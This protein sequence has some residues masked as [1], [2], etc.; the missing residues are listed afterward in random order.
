MALTA[1]V[2]V[3]HG[4]NDV[5]TSMLPAL[6]PSVQLRFGLGE[7]TLAALV[8]TFAFSSSLP[9]PLLGALAERISPRAAAALG[10]ALSATVLSLVGVVPSAALL[11][12][13][14]LIGGLGS[15]ALHPA[16]SVI[17]REAEADKADRAASLFTAGGMIGY[18]LGP[19]AILAIVAN[20]GLTATAWLMVPG[21]AL[22][23]ATFALLPKRSEPHARK[24][25]FDR[26]LLRGPVGLLTLVGV[27]S[28]LPF[29]TFLSGSALWLVHE[30]GLAPDATLIGL[31]LALF[32]LASAAGSVAG[33]WL[34]GWMRR[35]YV[36]AGSMLLSMLPL[37]G[38]FATASGS[39]TY[40]ASVAAAG[41][42]TYTSLPLLVVSAQNH[43]PQAVAAASG[44]LI[45]LS[46][47]LAAL[48]YVAI[49]WLQGVIGI[50]PA[51]GAA[52]LA[53]IP[54]AAL[55]LIVFR[56]FP[57]SA[58]HARERLFAHLPC[59]CRV[60]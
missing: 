3:A 59:G 29:L 24:R 11:F 32:S 54:A 4:V 28:H 8:A 15:A 36:I 41:V 34:S 52:Y 9:Q 17:V 6:L 13:L 22:A 43:A 60:S 44:M 21:L 33:A 30:R 56:K 20:F 53:M 37:Y 39:A 16:G 47:G 58:D 51:M 55:A 12:V 14:M 57:L 19:I 50:G 1:F 48:L 26:E 7:A 25:G 45:G 42:L 40:F 10:I 18:A 27:L 46:A 2:A 31:T 35:D 23:A 49:G 5:F 38:V